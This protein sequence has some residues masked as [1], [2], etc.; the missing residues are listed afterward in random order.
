MALTAFSR[1]EDREK[2]LAAGF[3]L[4]LPKP[5]KPHLLMAALALL[6][7]GTGA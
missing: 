1:A 6:L 7:G 5:F 3:D 2:A 4:H